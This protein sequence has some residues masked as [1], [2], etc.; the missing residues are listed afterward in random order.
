MKIALKK[1]ARQALAYLGYTAMT[2]ERYHS[3]QAILANVKQA[4]ENSESELQTLRTWFGAYSAVSSKTQPRA[5]EIYTEVFAYDGLHTDPRIIHNHDFMRDPRYVRAYNLGYEALGHDHKMFW[6]LHVALW[7]ASCGAKLEGD[8]VECGVWR[9]F[10]ST[11]IL[12]YVDWPRL[13]KHF[14]LF[15]TYAGLDERHLTQGELANQQKLDHFK[16]YFTDCYDF[17][18]QHFA[19]YNRVHVVRGTVPETLN[20]VKIDKVAFISIDMNCV[21]PEVAAAEHFWDR[22]AP[23]AVM[24]LDDYGFVSY[25]EQKRGFDKFAVGKGVEILALPTGQGIIIKP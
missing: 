21:L 24:L 3:E 25:E 11:A 23:G 4:T 5:A 1:L 10:L 13:N 12:N 7:A 9:G 16:H 6:R 8:F 19:A 22:M 15:D 2:L 20:Q 14:Y 18:K 17:V